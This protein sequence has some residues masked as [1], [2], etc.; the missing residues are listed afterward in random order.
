[1][2]T[3]V[4]HFIYFWILRATQNRAR[5]NKDRRKC[6]SFQIVCKWEWEKFAGTGWYFPSSFSFEKKEE[7]IKKN[8]DSFR[9]LRVTLSFSFFFLPLSFSPVHLDLLSDFAFL[10]FSFSLSIIS[11]LARSIPIGREFMIV[12]RATVSWWWL[13]GGTTGNASETNIRQT[14][15]RWNLIIDRNAGGRSEALSRWN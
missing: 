14:R 13:S 8:G 12:V 1:M 4:I 9:I 5:A 10:S 15:Y 11:I 7:K 6:N 2:E 3:I